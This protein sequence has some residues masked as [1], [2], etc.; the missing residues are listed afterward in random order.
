[1]DL[2]PIARVVAVFGLVLLVIAGL[3]FLAAKFNISLGKLPG[4]FVFKRG[5]FTCAVPLASSL[6]IS[7]VVT[8]LLN[9]LLALFKK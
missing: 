4:D 3:L 8:V 6:L 2:M 5:N 1:M 7:I 9:F